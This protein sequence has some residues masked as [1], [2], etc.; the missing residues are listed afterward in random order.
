MG[1]RQPPA[2]RSGRDGGRGRVPNRA[3]FL[4]RFQPNK[5]FASSARPG[6][7]C[8]R[9][10]RQFEL[11]GRRFSGC[12]TTCSRRNAVWDSYLTFFMERQ[13]GSFPTEPVTREAHPYPLSG[14]GEQETSHPSSSSESRRRGG[15]APPTVA[16]ASST[17]P[18]RFCCGISRRFKL[19]GRSW[20]CSHRED[21]TCS[22][23]NAVWD[24]YLM[25]FV[26]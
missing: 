13:E 12:C 23:R 3:A 22:R 21:T 8:C 9:I 7:F 20:A 5:A 11:L 2:S 19:L 26:E 16:F 24:S 17:R 4:K 1:R 25:F 14:E 6:R 15:S 18:G 10:S